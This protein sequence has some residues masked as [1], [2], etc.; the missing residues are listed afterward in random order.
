[1]DLLAVELSLQVQKNVGCQDLLQLCYSSDPGSRHES[2]R[3][4]L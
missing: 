3:R 2:H 4:K 1:M